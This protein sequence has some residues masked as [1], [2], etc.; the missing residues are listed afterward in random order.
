ML[1]PLNSIAQTVIIAS[2]LG[3]KSVAESELPGRLL[4]AGYSVVA[5]DLRGRGE[6]LG[7]FGA[8]YDTNYRLAGNQ[9]LMGQ[10]LAGRRAFDLMRAMDFLASRTD[11]AS[12]S[13][14]LIGLGDDALPALL[15][16]AVDRRV[17]RLVLAK[18]DHS[19]LFRMRTRTP[20]PPG[21]MG[22]AWNDP[23][24]LGRIRRNRCGSR[25]ISPTRRWISESKRAASSMLMAA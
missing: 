9:I 14:A 16:A 18:F 15:A 2:D 10:P 25:R 21:Q 4:A 12:N 19:V 17:Q 7:Y 6:T 22:D 8:H 23:Q 20:P 1:W 24:L 11:L 3:K 13:I 5:I